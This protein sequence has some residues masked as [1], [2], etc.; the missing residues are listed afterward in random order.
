MNWMDW[1]SALAKPS[2]TPSPKTIGVI[3]TILYPI[4]A[5]TFG[6]VFVQAFRQKVGWLIALTFAINLIANI[7]F[8][9]IFSG[10]RNVQLAALDILIV[11]ATIIWCVV[12]IWPPYRWVAVAQVSYFIWVSNGARRSS[13][14]GPR[15]R[16]SRGLGCEHD[17]QP[18]HR[19]RLLRGR[20]RRMA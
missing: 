16:R 17:F 4:I 11:W 12:A 9:P 10:M 18:P 2:W 1:Y 7:L 8:M 20:N 13:F 19:D 14:S 6:F 15:F 5:I 3:W